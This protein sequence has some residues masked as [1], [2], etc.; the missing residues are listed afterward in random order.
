MVEVAP[1]VAARAVPEM[2][3]ED[4]LESAASF[5]AGESFERAAPGPVLTQVSADDADQGIAAAPA[6]SL[7]QARD[8]IPAATRS[9]LAELFKAEVTTVRRLSRDQLR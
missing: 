9:L 3:A 6:P 1:A 5:G 4:A 8:Q 2:V 7:Q